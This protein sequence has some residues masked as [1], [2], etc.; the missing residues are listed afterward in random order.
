[1]SAYFNCKLRDKSIKIKSKKKHLNS[2]Y[3][4]Y[5]SMSITSIYS[6]TNPDFLHIEK[7]LKSMFL[8]II[9]KSAF[10]LIICKWELHFPDTIVSLKS[11]TLCSLSDGFYL[12]NFFYKKLNISRD[13]DITSLLYLK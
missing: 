3:H 9:K 10:Y 4:R 13:Y 2:Q 11:K 5:I 8:I 7:K 12:R 6:V 1:M